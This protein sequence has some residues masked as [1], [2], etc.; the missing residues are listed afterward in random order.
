MRKQCIAR[1]FRVILM[2][3]ALFATMGVS[4]PNLVAQDKSKPESVRNLVPRVIKKNPAQDFHKQA[5]HLVRTAA[6]EFVAGLIDF[7]TNEVCDDHQ[8]N[9]LS[10]AS[11]L[12]FLVE[13][14]WD[15]SPLLRR[16][17]VQYLEVDAKGQLRKV[18]KGVGSS[19]GEAAYFLLR[20]LDTLEDNS[21][22]P[23]VRNTVINVDGPGGYR[24]IL[25]AQGENVSQALVEYIFTEFP[26]DA[27]EAFNS[28]Y[29][30]SKLSPEE[31]D[32]AQHII[33]TA[34]WR[35]S[36]NY[37]D[38]VEEKLASKALERLCVDTAWYTRRYVVHI[39]LR[40]PFFRTPELVKK[41]QND[42]HPL[43]RDR[44][45]HI[46]LDTR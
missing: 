22:S 17:L 18:Y 25:R 43:V 12:L 5:A 24:E 31:F 41:L 21:M 19:R 34:G 42:P 44:A 1:G 28:V 27:W 35:L 32:L 20:H 11:S 6:P 7:A 15:Q 38:I 29:G 10:K 26:E 30:Q 40:Y 9:A 46:K 36:R 4:F 3:C 39:L 2:F 37:R 33:E 16:E 13:L 23:P 14:L 8:E 45:K